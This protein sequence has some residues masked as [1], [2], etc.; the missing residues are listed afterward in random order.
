MAEYIE[1]VDA[2]P[3]WTKVRTSDGQVVTVEGN[4]NWRNNNPGNI[5]Y[6]DFAKSMGAIGTDGR[7]AVF[8]TYEQG[9]D[10]KSNLIFESP[11]YRELPLS[12]A[13]SRYAPSFE[14]DT[15]GY[16][17]Q[18]AE[19]AGVSPN[20]PMSQIP[21]EKRAAILDAMQ[22]VEGWKVGTINGRP[23]TDYA[24]IPREPEF[25]DVPLPG[26]RPNTVPRTLM[27]YAGQ[28]GYPGSSNGLPP[29]GPTGGPALNAIMRSTA[30]NQPKQGGS[31][32]GGFMNPIKT[33]MG[34]VQPPIM[35]AASSPNVQRAAIGPLMGSLAGRTVIM[36]AL[37]NQNIG[38]A[39]QVTQGHSG[40]GTRAMAVTGRG[41]TPVMLAAGAAMR[42]PAP[43]PSYDSVLSGSGGG[44]FSG[45]D[46]G[47]NNHMSLPVYRA[48]AAVLGGGGF[49][50]SNIDR[51]LSS[52]Q[53]LYK[54]A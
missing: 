40:P 4:R 26:A 53:T 18:V 8:P 25:R 42:G 34:G 29:I 33:A 28:S 23:G 5:E 50:Q 21:L 43:T 24:A 10:A 30:P 54:L 32:W 37:M 14:N 46:S 17:R 6:G 44:A 2:G 20:T 16:L 45:G 13:I 22:R 11:N 39:P 7:F 38:Q 27:S 41:A 36:R 52:G 31:F 48:N 15:A 47:V 12:G 19:A 1:V 51:A 3:G 9:R 35:Q 49:N